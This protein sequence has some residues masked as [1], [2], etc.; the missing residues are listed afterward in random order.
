MIAKKGANFNGIDLNL[1]VLVCILAI[2]NTIFQL[3]SYTETQKYRKE[4]K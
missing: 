2:L 3:S 4:T 1:I